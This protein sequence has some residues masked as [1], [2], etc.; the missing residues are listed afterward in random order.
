MVKKLAKNVS[1]QI[2]LVFTS[3]QFGPEQRFIKQIPSFDKIHNEFHKN[4]EFGSNFVFKNIIT[5]L[6]DSLFKT[7][8][9]LETMTEVELRMLLTLSF[10]R[11]S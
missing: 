9:E 2:E 8:S 10:A 3:D 1:P 5:N 4:E 11:R 6:I 7:S